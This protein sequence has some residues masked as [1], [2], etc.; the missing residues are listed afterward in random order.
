MEV[1]GRSQTPKTAPYCEFLATRL[2]ML[3][4]SLP[5]QTNCSDKMF[6]LCVLWRVKRE[7]API[8]VNRL[9]CTT[10]ELR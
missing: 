6:I 2:H 7:R 1:L 5:L 8:A 3:N 4:S 9:G 10:Y